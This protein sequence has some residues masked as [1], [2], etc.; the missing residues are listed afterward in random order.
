[1]IQDWWA[2]WLPPAGAVVLAVTAGGVVNA[3]V[4]AKETSGDDERPVLGTHPGSKAIRSALADAGQLGKAEDIRVIGPVTR[5]SNNTGWIATVEPK[6]G[7]PAAKIIKR[8]PEIAAAFGVGVPQVA[9]DPAR[10]HNG[11]VVI[12]CFDED[13][14]S[15]DPIPSPLLGRMD[16]F[17]IWR[18]KI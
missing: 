2:I 9:I 8:Q 4:T 6:S 15:G 11:R 18:E 1:V 17:D 10:G 16:P 3:I 5:S 7:V 13:P 14:L 12:E